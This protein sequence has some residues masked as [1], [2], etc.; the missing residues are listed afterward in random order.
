MSDPRYELVGIED[1][2]IG[3][4]E[5]LLGG[6]LLSPYVWRHE[7]GYGLLLRA[8]PESGEPT[9]RIWFGRSDDGLRFVMDDAPAIAPSLPHLDVGG[10]EDPTVIVTDSALVVFYTGVDD[11][12]RAE[13]LWASGPNPCSLNKRGVAYSCSRTERNT[14]EASVLRRQDGGWC[15]FFEYTHDD[16][17]CLGFAIGP[18]PDGPWEEHDD[19]IAARPGGWD[20]HHLSTGPLLEEGDEVTMFYNGATPDARWAIGWAVFDSA[21]DM[22]LLYRCDEPLVAP[23]PGGDDDRAIAFA[24]SVI[25]DGD[26]IRLY[27]SHDDRTARRA[28]LRRRPAAG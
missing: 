4:H 26:L 8:V 12:G 2:V 17:S 11:A 27:L 3:G 5:A 9:G 23:E 28:T 18:Q 20:G 6:D 10:C 1:L 25:E 24:N 15:V 19:P 7:G 14:K 13:M 21:D 16:R 22:R